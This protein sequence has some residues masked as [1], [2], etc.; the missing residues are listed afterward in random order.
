MHHRRKLDDVDA[1]GHR[2]RRDAL[3]FTAWRPVRGREGFCWWR[4]VE[5][6]DVETVSLARR[7]RAEMRYR[8]LLIAHCRGGET[9]D[10]V[11]RAR[12]SALAKNLLARSKPSL[13][14]ALVPLLFATASPSLVNWTV[15]RFL[16]RRVARLFQ[17]LVAGIM[18]AFLLVE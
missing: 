1:C 2:D 6:D 12:C 5:N 16:A 7:T 4:T 13:F 18:R 9:R 14:L 3:N 8:L 10:R 11:P 15:G 17:T